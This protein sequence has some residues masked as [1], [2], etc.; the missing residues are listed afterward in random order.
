M[1]LSTASFVHNVSYDT[2]L[3][4]MFSRTVSYF[5]VAFPLSK[6]VNVPHYV[7]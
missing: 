3:F 4:H 6:E 5:F 1:V 7:Y 2:T